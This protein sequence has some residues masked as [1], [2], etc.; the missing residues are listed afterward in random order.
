MLNRTREDD[1]FMP[2]EELG[3]VDFEDLD[4]DWDDD[5]DDDWD[6]EDFE[7]D[8]WDDELN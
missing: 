7:D 6:E 2:D 4:D 5:I 3:D 8:D 1:D